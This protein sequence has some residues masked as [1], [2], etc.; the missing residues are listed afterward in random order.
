MKTA[1]YKAEGSQ[2]GF[3]PMALGPMNRSQQSKFGALD[4]A[5]IAGLLLVTSAVFGLV[6]SLALR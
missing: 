1:A 6:M 4:V 3:A 2:N 5:I